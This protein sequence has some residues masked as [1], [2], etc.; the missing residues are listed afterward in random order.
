M[1]SGMVRAAIS[2]FVTESKSSK[3]SDRWKMAKKEVTDFL[4]ELSDYIRLTEF[5]SFAEA[6]LQLLE[7]HLDTAYAGCIRSRSVLKEK[8]WIEVH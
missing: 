8:A 5:D 3:G 7:K 2:S 4:Q 1:A 6:L